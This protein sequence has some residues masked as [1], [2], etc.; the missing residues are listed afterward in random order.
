MMDFGMVGMAVMGSNLALNI[1]DH[2]YDVACYNYTRDLTDKVLAEHPHPHMH[3]FF[4]AES[5]VKSLKR[6]RKIMLLIMA[7]SPVDSTLDTLLPLL[8][9]GDIILDGGNSFFEDTRRRCERAKAA[10][11]RYFGVGVSGGEKGARNGPALMPGGDKAAYEEVRPIYEAI[12]AKVGD[13]PCCTYIGEDGAGHYVKMVHNGIEY[14]DM[15]LIAESYLLLKEVG[16]LT[17]AEIADAFAAWNEGELKSFL[18]GITARIFREADDMGPGEL[19]DV[20]KDSAGQKGTGRWTSIE[21]MKEGVNTSLITAACNARITSNQT[22]VRREMGRLLG[23]PTGAKAGKEFV[24][25]VRQSLYLGKIVAYAQGFDLYKAAAKTYG[26]DLDYGRI[27]SIFRGGCIIQ[28]E[29]LNEIT[30]AYKRNPDLEN[31]ML[32]E[33][34]SEKIRKNLDS[35]RQVAGAAIGNGIPAPAL[36][37]AVGYIDAYR[38]PLLGANLIQAQRDCFGAHT[39]ERTDR[40]GVFHHQW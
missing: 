24:E 3:G 23:D 21:A 10:G 22:I 33:F 28:A 6:P 2:G 32:D 39:Y 30:K 15:Q 34:F 4:D 12:A 20:I 40:E 38:A 14:A 7:G 13:E 11:I 19:V 36:L 37:E 27:A 25:A 9:E 16:S 8:E 18:I 26:W 17:N 5:F 35:L 1:A 31:L 29:F